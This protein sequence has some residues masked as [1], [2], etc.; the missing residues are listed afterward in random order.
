MSEEMDQLRAE[1]A[2][3]QEKLELFLEADR[4]RKEI[5]SLRIGIERTK[6]QAR[7][8]PIL[9]DLEAEHGALGD[10]IGKVDTPMGMIVVKRPSQVVYKRLQSSK[11]TP[12][13]LERF[14]RACLVYPT[15]EQFNTIISEYP[16]M[17]TAAA[18]EAA[19]LA[20]LARKEASGK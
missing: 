19:H 1:L 18:D 20:G 8:L 14:A 16:H 2:A 5:E 12:E 6:R 17:T 15:R 3:E 4:E 10:G 9:R 7:E 11:A 13:D